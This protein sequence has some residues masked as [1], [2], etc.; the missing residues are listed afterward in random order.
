MASNGEVTHFANVEDEATGEGF[1][2]FEFQKV[3]GRRGRLLVEREDAFDF[4]KVFSRLMKFNADLPSNPDDFE[5]QVQRTIDSPPLHLL[6]HAASTGWRADY[7]AFV[8]LHEAIDFERSPAETSSARRLNDSQLRGGKPEGDLPGWIEQVARP[9]G[10]SDLGIFVLSAAFAALLLKLAD[11]HSFGIYIFGRSKTGKSIILVAGSSVAGVG[12]EGELLNWAATSAALGELCGLHCDRLMPINEV[13]LIKKREAYAKI[14]PMIYQ[15]A[16]G[17]ER[18]RH[19]KSSFAIAHDGGQRRT[20]FVSTAERSLDDYAGLADASRDEGELA[21]CFEISSVRNGRATVIDRYPASVPPERRR[22]WATALL[23]RLRKTCARHHGVALEPFVRFLM[24]DIQGAAR[25]VEAYMAEFMREIDTT[26]ISGAAEHAA[27]NCSLV[28]AGGCM[29]IEAGL[30]P[31]RKEEVLRAITRCFCDTLEAARND[32]DPLLRTKRLLRSWLRSDRVVELKISNDRFDANRYQGYAIG[33]GQRRRYVVRAASMRMWL[34]RQ[35]GGFRDAVLWLERQ[36]RLQPRQS[37]TAGIARPIGWRGVSFGP[38]GRGTSR[39]ARSS[40]TS[41]SRS[42]APAQA[43]GR[44][45]RTPHPTGPAGRRASDPLP[46][47]ERATGETW[48]L[49]RRQLGTQGRRRVRAPQIAFR[50]RRAREAL[51]DLKQH[52]MNPGSETLRV[53]DKSP[54]V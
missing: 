18:E 50:H 49:V 45:D 5:D 35:P 7:S 4:E 3:G 44:R 33:V 6:R 12:R 27:E 2:V 32:D 37:R 23:K 9:C 11:R 31:Y 48:A 39:P 43:R 10:Y 8:A 42:R 14:Q 54:P 22:A 20:I 21:R 28:Y 53:G 16:E 30:L 41:R 24:R 34:S 15:I 29:A 51:G 26:G 46:V 38:P 19:S 36:R 25:R 13:G 17:R 47:R 52:G 40:S 1:E